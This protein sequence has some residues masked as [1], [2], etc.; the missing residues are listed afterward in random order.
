MRGRVWVSSGRGL[1]KEAR[2][3]ASACP[4]EADTYALDL[5]FASPTAYGLGKSGWVTARFSRGAKPP[6]EMLKQWIDESFRAVAP[7]RLVALPSLTTPAAG[8]M[9]G[10]GQRC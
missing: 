7:K 6:V 1:Q 3:G 9:V 2:P 4:A 8:A 5:P 10:L